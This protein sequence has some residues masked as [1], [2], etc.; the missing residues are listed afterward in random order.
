M[1]GREAYIEAMR[2]MREM[3]AV[4]DTRTIEQ[5]RVAPHGSVAHMAIW[6]VDDTESEFEVDIVNLNTVRAELMDRI[7]FFPVERLADAL[8]RLDELGRG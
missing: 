4:T 1:Q 5:H 3:F 6:C 8:A 2:V 7:E